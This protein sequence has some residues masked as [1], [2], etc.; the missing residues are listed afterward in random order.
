MRITLVLMVH[1][2]GLGARGTAAASD[3]V[4]H[5]T[6]AQKAGGGRGHRKRYFRI[7]NQRM[8]NKIPS[9]RTFSSATTLKLVRR[10]SCGHAS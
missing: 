5:Q 10:V 4:C 1:G 7:R 6:W 9:A 3:G 2:P 8:L